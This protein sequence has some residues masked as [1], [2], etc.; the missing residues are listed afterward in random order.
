MERVGLCFAELFADWVRDF[1]GWFILLG[2][3]EEILFVIRADAVRVIKI[4]V[5]YNKMQY[6]DE[7]IGFYLQ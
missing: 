3:F 2:A 5:V 7:S 4:L 1:P 6:I